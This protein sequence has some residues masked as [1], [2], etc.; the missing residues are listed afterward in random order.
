[1][2]HKKS[3][4]LLQSLPVPEWK[5]D[6]ITTDFVTRFPMTRGQKDTIWVVVDHLTKVANFIPIDIKYFLE[7]LAQLYVQEIVRLHGVPSCIVQI[8][9]LDLLLNSGRSFKKLCEEN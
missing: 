6:Y 5:W 2:D 8:E 9:T 3:P 1:M 4:G 7:K